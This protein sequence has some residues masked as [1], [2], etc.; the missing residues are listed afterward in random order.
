VQ[1][2]HESLDDRLERQREVLEKLLGD[3]GDRL[4]RG[5]DALATITRP[6]SRTSRAAGRLIDDDRREGTLGKALRAALT[7]V[8]DRLERLLKE[9][10]Q[11]LAAVRAKSTPAGLAKLDAMSARHAAELERD[12]L[13]LDDLVGG[14]ASRISRRSARS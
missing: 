1:N 10:A 8:A 3:L 12:V 13:L 14:S 2:A 6:R 11:G 4:E 5:P 9:E 7:G